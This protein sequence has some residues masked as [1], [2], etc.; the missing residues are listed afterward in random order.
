VYTD[1][2]WTPSPRQPAEAKPN[3]SQ[4]YLS[5]AKPPKVNF[6][7]TPASEHGGSSCE[8]TNNHLHLDVH[9]TL[10]GE[11]VRDDE[12]DQGEGVPHRSHIPWQSEAGV[13]V[14]KN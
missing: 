10:Q 8:C 4:L 1:L 14:R 11:V 6:F 9:L 5:S 7:K 12:G 3:L 13:L 2:S